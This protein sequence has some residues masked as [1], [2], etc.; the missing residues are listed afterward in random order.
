LSILTAPEDIDVLVLEMG[1][2]Y[3]HG[4]LTLLASIARPDIGVVT[5]VQ[6]VHLER[7]GT[8]EAIAQTK[9]ELVAA[10]PKE[11]CA[12]LNGDDPRVRQMA[13]LAQG[14]VVFYG[15]GPNN[16]VQVE[17]VV[18]NGLKGSTFWLTANG[19]R[20]HVKIPF[21]G[22]AGVQTALVALAVGTTFNLDI[23]TMMYGLKDPGIEVRLIFVPGP[24]GSQLIDDTY[25]AS[26][27]SMLSALDVLAMVPA[28]RR[29]A[30]LGEMR[31]LGTSSVEEHRVVGGRAGVVA[32]VLLTY[33]ELAAPLAEAAATSERNTGTEL[34]L[35]EFG[36]D[37]R[38]ELLAW[39]ETHL[40]PGDVVL[41]KG[42][43]GLE[44][45]HLVAA[46]RTEAQTDAD[47]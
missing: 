26:R 14:R 31:E 16:H 22:S 37:Q 38:D 35:H 47:A 21:L 10:L 27:P 1:G 46:L 29:V 28:T 20:T 42:S 25:N 34:E 9:G 24:R 36:I 45:E 44:M 11:G 32:D 13:A 30:V 5:N 39:L 7:M 19:K 18:S 8:I 43:R 3:A 23:A 17:D 2:A 41:L 12:V 15:L 6:P 33:G 40:A 4:E